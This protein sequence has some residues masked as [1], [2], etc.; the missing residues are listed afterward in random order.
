MKGKSLN[1]ASHPSSPSKH[2]RVMAGLLLIVELSG[3][4]QIPALVSTQFTTTPSFLT[5]NAYLNA[6]GTNGVTATR[7]PFSLFC[8]GKRW[9]IKT[10]Y[11]LTLL[12]VAKLFLPQGLSFNFSFRL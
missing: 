6:F 1:Q 7:T 5:Y 4:S 2:G 11:M 10:N 8:F 9:N 3:V 12:S